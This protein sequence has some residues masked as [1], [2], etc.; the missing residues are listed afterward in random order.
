[1]S[2]IGG[3]GRDF[4]TAIRE[5]QPMAYAEMAVGLGIIVAVNLLFFRN[6]WGFF[7]ANP[8]PFWI[9]ILPIAVRYGAVPGYSVGLLSALVYLLFVIFQPRSVFAVDILSQE[10]LLN[11]VLF[12]VVGGALGELR[13]A[14]KRGQKR[15]AKRVDELEEGL[16]DLA[17]RYLA[18]IEVNRELERRIVSQTSTMTTLYQAAKNLERLDIDTLSPSIL[19]LV[20]SFI[21]AESCA[22]YLRQDGRYLLKQGLPAQPD[23]VRPTELDVSRGMPAITYGD[24]R[25]ATVRDVITEAT[26]AQIMKQRLLMTTPLLGPNQEVLGILT[27]EKM[28]FLRFTPTAVKMFTLLGDW[29]STSFQTAL[30]F[31]ETQDRNIADEQTG[32][33]S[34]PYMFKRL[35]EE[36]VRARY[37]N[38]PLVVLAVQISDFESIV[39]VKLP[40]VLQVL[41]LVFRQNIRPIDI[42]G[43]YATDDIFLIALPHVADDEGRGLALR[44]RREVEGF[45]FRPFESD[46]TLQVGLGMGS[47]GPTTNSAEEIIAQAVQYFRPAVL[48]KT[49]R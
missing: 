18:A 2:F 30:R 17:Q 7:E 5:T 29:A 34:Y 38:L 25:T 16:Q 13:E 21:E 45:G 14:Q 23:F 35:N 11:P 8:H 39:P 41:G 48:T 36:V 6:N 3:Y 37:Y 31:Q 47:L 19:E 49:E 9:A 10:A 44:I 46:Q 20:T 1:M 4:R 42:L 40:N 12:I 26:P 24:R 32:A 15:L 27:V 28:P 33:Y 22:L 43:K